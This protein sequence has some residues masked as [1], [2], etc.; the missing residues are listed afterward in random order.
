MT[1]AQVLKKSIKNSVISNNQ[2][3]DHTTK[4]VK[5][6]PPKVNRSFGYQDCGVNNVSYVNKTQYKPK[7]KG[8]NDYHSKV[9]QQQAGSSPVACV[10]R[11]ALLSSDAIIPATESAQQACTKNFVKSRQTVPSHSR[12][13]V[14]T[15][16]STASTNDADFQDSCTAPP[17]PSAQAKP[18]TCTKYE[19]PLRIKSKSISYKEVLPSCPTL[20]LW[21]AQNKYKFGFIPLGGQLMPDAVRAKDLDSDPIALH[22]II[23]QASQYNFLQSQ[24]NIRSQ[25]NPDMWDHYLQDYWD[26]QLPLLIR[27][28]FPLD[29][30]RE[31]SLKSQDINL[32]SAL[33]FPDDVSA[34]L[35]EEI[36]HK[37]ILGPFQQVPVKNLHISPMMTREKSKAQHCRVIVDLSFSQGQ[38]VNAGILKDQY[39][40]TPFILKLPT[41]D[42][43]TDQVK[44]LGRGCKLYKVDISRAFRHIKLDPK[45]Y[46]L[47]G[48]RHNGYYVDTCLP[49]GYC[50]GSVIFQHLSDAVRHI[51]CQRQFDVTNYINDLLGI[52]LPSKIDA[53][54]DTLRHLLHKL[55]FEIS[56]KKLE[57]PTTCLNCLGIDINTESFTMSIPSEKLKDIWDMCLQWR[58]K[59]QCS[60]RQLQSLLGSLLYI[61][62][63]IKSS[64]FFLNRLLDVLRSMEDKKYTVITREA[65]R[66]INRFL[67]FIPLYNG[68]TFFDQKPIDF[69]T[70]LDASLQG[71]GARWGADL[72]ALT[73][74][75]GYLDLQ[76]VHLEM[77]NILVAL[78]VWQKPWANKK[79]AIACDNLAVVQVLNLG[80]HIATINVNLK[81]THIPGKVNT[82]A[83]LLSRWS[84]RSNANTLLHQLLPSHT[85]VTANESHIMIDW[86][87]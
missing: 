74:P 2:G 40:S 61:S 38:S 71:L 9:R 4:T 64:R 56:E 57:P 65:K 79:V 7:T 83:D 14:V 13:K 60:K 43:I 27:F 76:I 3:K 46:D 78:T 87:I 50:N 68:V 28:G 39:L 44:S 15:N 23:S 54:Y 84:T 86:S 81:V 72:Y 10:N 82:I 52:D 41:V 63:C 25:L 32:T 55:G 1:Y 21:E 36:K 77:L 51:M 42:T 73:I 67:K 35:Q 6:V 18:S 17:P 33:E 69:S 26:K 31:G 53:S 37:A 48:L 59:A 16:K 30:R 19:L 66:D 5:Q 70:E 11:F 29:Y 85:W 20:Q 12:G 24:I 49:F 22:N 34:Y 75:L 45:K 62:K 80:F 58:H 8:Y 47:L